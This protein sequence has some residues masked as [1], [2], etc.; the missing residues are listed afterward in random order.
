M[1]T[2]RRDFLKY[3]ASAL[4]GLLVLPA[5]R[6]SFAQTVGP[7]ESPRNAF[8]QGVA[9]ADPQ[10]DAVLLWGRV[11]PL[12]GEASPEVVVQVSRF[13]AFGDLVLEETLTASPDSDYTMRLLV[14]DLDSDTTYYYRFIAADGA[15]SRLGR[16]WT[17]PP[18]NA[19]RPVSIAFVSCQNWPPNEHGVYQR[20][21]RDEQASDAERGVDLILHLGDYVYGLPAD[22]NTAV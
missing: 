16:T 10:P 2:R 8:P 1:T 5:S 15:T 14:R 11:E 18:V 19:R 9:S 13:P 22:A 21:I 7:A 20:L 6:R 4:A 3:S 17:A 12:A